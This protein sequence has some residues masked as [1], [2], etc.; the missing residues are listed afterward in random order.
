MPCLLLVAGLNFCNVSPLCHK[1]FMGVQENIAENLRANVQ[2][3]SP[4]VRDIFESFEFRL[5]LDRLEKPACNTRQPNAS[6]RST[7]TRK[8]RAMPR[9]GWCLGS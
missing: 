4:E 7:C 5:Q 3:F 8:R 6:P 2:G 9:W 1:A